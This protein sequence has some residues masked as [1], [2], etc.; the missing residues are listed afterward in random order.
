[1]GM[2][3]ELSDFGCDRARLV[4]PLKHP[5]ENIV[6]NMQLDLEFMEDNIRES[7]GLTL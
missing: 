5:R 3:R 7:L 2:A 6:P 1:M 4:M